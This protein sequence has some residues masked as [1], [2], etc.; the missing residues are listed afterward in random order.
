MAWSRAQRQG[1]DFCRKGQIETEK[2]KN[3]QKYAKARNFLSFLKIIC[4]DC[5]AK[6]FFYFWMWN[7]FFSKN[8]E[9]ASV[10]EN[11]LFGK[12]GFTIKEN[13]ILRSSIIYENMRDDKKISNKKL[14]KKKKIEKILRNHS[15]IF[16]WLWKI[17]ISKSPQIWMNISF[18]KY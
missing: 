3:A 11:M 17:E 9:Y 13:E 7:N 14:K 10:H 15:G 2:G 8:C 18:A 16:F 6:H 12:K 1:C 4:P 5:I